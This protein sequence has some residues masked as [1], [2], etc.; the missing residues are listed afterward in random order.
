MKRVTVYTLVEKEVVSYG[1]SVPTYTA[2]FRDISC[3]AGEYFSNRSIKE[4]HLPIQRFCWV[5]GKEIFAAFD[6]EVLELIGC[7]QSQKDNELA[8]CVEKRTKPL[9]QKVK[10]YETMTFWQRIKF[11]FVNTIEEKK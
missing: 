6:E 11:V 8:L 2:D 3:Q 5:G 7:L 1:N 4:V 9:L 10:Q